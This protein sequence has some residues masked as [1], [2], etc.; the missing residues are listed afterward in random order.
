MDVKSFITLAQDETWTE[1]STL[2]SGVLV[3]NKTAKLKVENLAKT[4]FRFSPV[5]YC[6]PRFSLLQYE[7]NYSQKCFIEQ[8][9]CY[10]TFY[11]CKL[12]AFVT[13]MKNTYCLFQI[14]FITE[15][16]NVQHI[17]ITQ[18]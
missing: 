11:G 17:I 1:F 15:Y 13:S 10:E 7:I 2:G 4:T 9:Q 3:H 6:A 16:P 8:V 12:R 18:I 5:G 14:K